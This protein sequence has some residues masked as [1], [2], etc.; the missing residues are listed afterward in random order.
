M[1][2]TETPEDRREKVR[3]LV[4]EETLVYLNFEQSQPLEAEEL[5]YDIV[6]TAIDPEAVIDGLPLQVAQGEVTLPIAVEYTRIEADGSETPLGT[7]LKRSQWEYRDGA[8][9]LTGTDT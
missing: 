2:R 3:D 8:W 5:S 6:A 7:L 9:L 1:L 4:A